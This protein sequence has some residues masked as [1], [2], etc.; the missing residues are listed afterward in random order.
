M[1]ATMQNDHSTDTLGELVVSGIYGV[2]RQQCIQKVIEII[3]QSKDTKQLL[4]E[5]LISVVKLNIPRAVTFLHDVGININYCTAL[6]T[7]IKRRSQKCSIALIKLGAN[8]RCRDLTGKS[9]LVY[10]ARSVPPQ[11]DVMRLLLKHGHLVKVTDVCCYLPLINRLRHSEPNALEA[12]KLLLAAGEQVGDPYGVTLSQDSDGIEEYKAWFQNE[13]NEFSLQN[14]CRAAIRKHLTR[15][16][17]IENL[18]VQTSKLGL[19]KSVASY[20]VYDISL[21]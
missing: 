18:F 15:G 6:I 7:A 14:K 12:V 4:K 5:L 11:L 19:P 10:A 9:P 8:I 3:N 2:N 17:P 20:L 21:L 1:A 13:V 16:T